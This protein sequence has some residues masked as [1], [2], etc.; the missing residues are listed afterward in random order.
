MTGPPAGSSDPKTSI[1]QSIQR[2]SSKKTACRARRERVFAQRGC[3]RFSDAFECSQ[4]FGRHLIEQNRQCGTPRCESTPKRTA[5]WAMAT[6][7]KEMSR[8][9]EKR[10]EE[11]TYELQSLMRISYAVFCLKKKKQKNSKTINNH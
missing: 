4:I 6:A 5:A 7:V 10:S 2:R 11:H 3:S 9:Q 8:P 1:G